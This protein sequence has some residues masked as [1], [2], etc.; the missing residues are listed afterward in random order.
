M[1]KTTLPALIQ[2]RR[3][4]TPVLR[5]RYFRGSLSRHAERN[6]IV[7]NMS[8]LLASHK[9]S[10]SCLK[11]AA[12]H[13]LASGSGSTF[14]STA[15]WYRFCALAQR[16][17]CPTSNLT[18]HKFPRTCAAEKNNIIRMICLCM[19]VP[20]LMLSD[21]SGHPLRWYKDVQCTCC[22]GS[23]RQDRYLSYVTVAAGQPCAAA[24]IMYLID[25][26]TTPQAA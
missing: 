14:A 17:P 8:G 13:K 24:D 19:K 22:Y 23:K 20:C 21:S 2:V 1:M 12:V 3:S 11:M 16:Q 15:C 18:L 9:Q 26:K 5:E 4:S 6:R 10:G 25:F 7:R